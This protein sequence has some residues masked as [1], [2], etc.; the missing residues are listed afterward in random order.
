MGY[1]DTRSTARTAQMRQGSSAVRLRAAG[2]RLCNMGQK[3]SGENSREEDERRTNVH[4]NR[5]GL[6]LE[7]RQNTKFQKS[8]VRK[9]SIRMRV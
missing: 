8:C 9:C 2:V 5:N 6:A 7:S 4:I 3:F 1:Y